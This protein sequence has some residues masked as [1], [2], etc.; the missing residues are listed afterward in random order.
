MSAGMFTVS[1]SCAVIV[2]I[3]CGTL[4][5]F[6]GLPWTAFVLLAICPILLTG[7][8]TLLSLHAAAKEPHAGR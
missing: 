1:F 4:W 8:G 2:P 3:I 6:T 5:D 7:L